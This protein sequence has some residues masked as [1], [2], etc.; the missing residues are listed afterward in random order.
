MKLK[1][2][3]SVLHAV[4]FWVVVDKN[5]FDLTRSDG[6]TFAAGECGADQAGY[7]SVNIRPSE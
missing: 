1:S 4:S 2:A 5:E 3:R 6:V 7:F